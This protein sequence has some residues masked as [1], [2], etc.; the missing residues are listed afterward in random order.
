ME[1]S[2]SVNVLRSGTASFGCVSI[3]TF[4][5]HCQFVLHNAAITLFSPDGSFPVSYLPHS[6]CCQ[7]F[8][9]IIIT[10]KSGLLYWLFFHLLFG[11]ASWDVE[12]FPDGSE[13]KNP[14]AMQEMQETWVRSMSQEN[15]LEE[16]VATH[17]SILAWRIPWTEEPGRRYSPWDRK[18]LD[19]V[20]RLNTQAFLACFGFAQ[21]YPASSVSTFAFGL[22]TI[23]IPQ[24][25]LI[26][27][28]WVPPALRNS[29]SHQ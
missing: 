8:I 19:M 16:E 25:W 5:R 18:D 12:G 7:R 14:P 13:V 29:D 4:V 27:G 22:L 28:P 21:Y 26:F 20:E 15:L 9:I 23:G 10:I 6:W 2:S 1:P 17:S 11:H 3:F 24:L